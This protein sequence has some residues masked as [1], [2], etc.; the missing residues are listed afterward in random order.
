MRVNTVR[1]VFEGCR[2]TDRGCSTPRTGGGPSPKS[3]K[4]KYI[5]VSRVLIVLT[6]E[7]HHN[8]NATLE[9]INNTILHYIQFRTFQTQ[10]GWYSETYYINI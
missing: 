3:E 2:L 7:I 9:S 6:Y 4:V 8:I 5:I 10:R 1:S